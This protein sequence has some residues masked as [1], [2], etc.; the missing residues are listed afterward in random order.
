MERKLAGYEPERVL[1]YFEELCKIPHGSGNTGAI[2]DYCASFARERGLRYIQDETGNVIIFKPASAGYEKASAVILQGHLDMVA[3]KTPDSSHDFLRD[4]LDLFVEEDWIGARDTT[5][6]G[7]DGIAVAYALAILESDTILHPPLE[8]VFT[9]DEETGMDG[10]QALD[11][12][13]LAGRYLINLDS[14]NEG[15]VLASCAG[16]L[17]KNCVLPVERTAMDGVL[18]HLEVNG[19]RG[20]HSGAEIHTE[21]GNAVILAGRLLYEISREIPLVLCAMEGGLK[22]NA[23]PRLC[24]ADILIQKG[25]EN[26]LEELV[27]GI[28]ADLKNEYQMQ[29]PQVC[30]LCQNQGEARTEAVTPAGTTRILFFLNN[31][32]NGV[33]AMSH[34]IAGLVETSLNLGVM[35]LTEEAFHAHFSIR[36]SVRSRKYVLCRKLEFLCELLGGEAESTAEY[37]EWAFRSESHLRHVMCEAY[38]D[39]TGKSMEVQAIHA[40]LECGLFDD[41]MPGVDMVSIGPDMRDIHTTAERLSIPSVER[42]WRLL[43]EVLRRLRGED[44]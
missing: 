1:Y 39:L 18:Y 44:E 11:T 40:G 14:E 26:R 23:I 31:C 42:T 30:V 19:L 2:S 33:Q 21:R 13:V 7:D 22:D 43:C 36:S 32:P 35:K 20:G 10:A 24:T 25:S 37:P 4:G 16:G 12:S 41:R 9:I 15:T 8:C 27:Q 28:E 3:E 5:L 38:R 6:G 29:D 34:H 17:R